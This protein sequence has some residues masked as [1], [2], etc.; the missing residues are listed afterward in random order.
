MNVCLTETN[1][2]LTLSGLNTTGGLTMRASASTTL[3]ILVGSLLGLSSIPVQA[4][5]SCPMPMFQNPLKDIETVSV[6]QLK[7][8]EQA[9]KHHYFEV[10]PDQTAKYDFRTEIEQ[11]TTDKSS[12]AFA[13]YANGMIYNENIK[14]YVGSGIMI[15]PCHM[16]TANH[17]AGL[18]KRDEEALT[19]KVVQFEFSKDPNSHNFRNRIKGTVVASSNHD[20]LDYAVVEFNRQDDSVVYVPQCSVAILK[21]INQYPSVSVGY[22]LMREDLSKPAALYGMRVRVHDFGDN[23]KAYV[24]SS[25]RDSGGPILTY[26]K[27]G[28]CV[29]GMKVRASNILT[30]GGRKPTLNHGNR[31]VPLANIFGDLARRNHNLRNRIISAQESGQCN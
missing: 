8:E 18:Q 11:T 3:S 9:M 28:F 12:P 29:S 17:V 21:K 5:E 1:T 6:E 22:P 26:T 10:L 7:H 14:K 20:K 15:S 27:N 4:A 31:I 30:A 23:L 2:I 24:N 19:G 13:L 25:H 16:L